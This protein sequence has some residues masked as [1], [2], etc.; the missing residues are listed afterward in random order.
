MANELLISDLTVG[1]LQSLIKKT[2]QEAMAEVLIEFTIAAELDAEVTYRA[3][4][5]DCLRSHLQD[6]PFGFLE[7]EDALEL[8]D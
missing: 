8:D 4:M 7:F 3:E 5:A 6:K 2:V 1:E